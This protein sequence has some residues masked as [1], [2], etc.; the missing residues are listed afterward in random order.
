MVSGI[1]SQWLEKISSRITILPC[2]KRSAKTARALNQYAGKFDAVL[3][4]S[5]DFT[6]KEFLAL[7]N[8]HAKMNIGYGLEKHTIYDV[9]IPNKEVNVKARYVYAAKLFLSQ[10]QKAL[11]DATNIQL[12]MLEYKAIRYAKLNTRQIAIN[13][14]GASEYR[15]FSHESAKLF[16]TNWLQQWPN[17]VLVL[18]PVPDFMPFLQRLTTEINSE[19]LILPDE[20]PSLELTLGILSSSSLCVTPDTSVVHMASC[21]NIPTLAIYSADE[22]NYQ[23]WK[24]FAERNA[25]IFNPAPVRKSVKVRV[26]EFSWSELVEKKNVLLS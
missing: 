26:D 24:P 15:Q 13:F 19:R 1:P 20:S 14:F 22:R 4:L 6:Y 5:S 17:E 23:E 7:K 10:E 8:L 9:K 25:V 2:G 11:I 3:D 12:P 18:L 21:L 16:I